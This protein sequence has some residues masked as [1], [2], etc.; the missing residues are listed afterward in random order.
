MISLGLWLTGLLLAGCQSLMGTARVPQFYSG[1]VVVAWHAGVSAVSRQALARLMG[2]DT[3]EEREDLALWSVSPGAETLLVERLKM[4]PDVRVAELNYRR[5]TTQTQPNRGTANDPALRFESPVSG[6]LS[7]W[8]LVAIG[9]EA[10]WERSTGE[11]VTVAVIDTGVDEG[12]PDLANRVLGNL[13]LNLVEKGQRAFDDHGHGTHVAG[14]IAGVRN[15]GIGSAGVAPDA[16]IIPIRVIGADGSGTSFDTA[17]AVLYAI[18]QKV[19]IL[20]MSLGA[21]DRSEVEAQAIRQAQASGVLVVAAAGNEAMAGNFP[22][23]PASY[24]GV[25]SV[26][27]V[28]PDFTRAPFSNYNSGVTLAAPG[29]DVFST[30]PTRFGTES[31]YGY[32]S[33]T[34]MAAPFVSG[35]A[36]LIQSR[37][38]DWSAAM[39]RERLMR[40]A[41]D[42]VVGNDGPGPDIFFGHGLVNASQAVAD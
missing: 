19:R 35:V 22:E 40:T 30:L 17:Q 41:R 12:H 5:K 39:V 18:R 10:A 16:Q 38:P 20:N 25:V 21:A 3:L 11:G 13:G 24:P 31:P 15:N 33:G 23:Y 2:A 14:I 27:A 36:A 42:L 32:L 29:V 4:V 8:S 6:Q 26:A 7:A 1:Q 28:A 37:Y 9:A 34:S